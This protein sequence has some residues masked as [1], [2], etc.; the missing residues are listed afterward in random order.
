MKISP[1]PVD[2]GPISGSK[3][4]GI[5]FLM[6]LNFSLI[7]L[8]AKYK[9]VSSLKTTVTCDKPYREMERVYDKFGMPVSA[10]STG[11]VMRCSVSRGE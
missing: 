2:I 9:S 8:R 5:L 6:A 3:P 11:K 7:R 4:A 1:N 10:V